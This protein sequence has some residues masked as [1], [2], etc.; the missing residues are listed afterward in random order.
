MNINDNFQKSDLVL[1]QELKKLAQNANHDFHANLRG[2]NVLQKEYKLTPCSQL[3]DK[4]NHDYL[5][6]FFEKSVRELDP[7]HLSIL[8]EFLKKMTS[9]VSNMSS[10]NQ[11]L[12]SLEGKLANI[13]RHL[14][15]HLFKTLSQE[16]EHSSVSEDEFA[17]LI[18][19][20]HEEYHEKQVKHPDRYIESI[21]NNRKNFETRIND[22]I[23]D[24]HEHMNKDF[25]K[26]D[27]VSLGIS[28]WLD[29]S[30]KDRLKKENLLKYVSH[31]KKT[32]YD[33]VNIYRG[34]SNLEDNLD[35]RE[36][37]SAYLIRSSVIR[38]FKRGINYVMQNNTDEFMHCWKDAPKGFKESDLVTK[39]IEN[40]KLQLENP[41]TNDH[42]YTIF[43]NLQPEEFSY[44]ETRLLE[45]LKKEAVLGIAD[46][47]ADENLI[48]KVFSELKLVK[49]RNEFV[50][51]L[52]LSEKI[53]LGQ[54]V[55]YMESSNID[56]TLF[57]LSASVIRG[58]ASHA[59]KLKMKILFN[60]KRKRKDISYK[61]AS[62][63]EDHL[64]A[65]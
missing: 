22:L 26:A 3:I 27:E 37:H 36:K 59:D 63:L 12:E 19:N 64:E 56:T 18:K 57:S 35:H 41:G 39:I 7:E 49:D 65:A 46:N 58:K 54:W 32:I 9:E 15:S 62:F 16:G 52:I 43:K 31:R 21:D 13:K 40:L 20:S 2:S 60:E 45:E 25:S 38:E 11:Q 23:D 33:L 61:K 10:E 14:R 28:Q 55:E 47:T 42:F 30:Q 6:H 8:Y 29:L 51:H 24:H 50:E 1:R 5:I 44:P 4:K 34:L 53:S 48:C 17:D